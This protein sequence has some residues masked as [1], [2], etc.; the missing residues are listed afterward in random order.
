VAKGHTEKGHGTKLTI[1]TLEKAKEYSKKKL[2]C[3]AHKDVWKF[4]EDMGFKKRSEFY[5]SWWGKS[6]L[7]ELELMY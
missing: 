6:A 5:D 2:T 7:M 4:F 1:F 3:K